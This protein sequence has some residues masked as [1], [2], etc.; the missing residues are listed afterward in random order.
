M[1]SLPDLRS[2]FTFKFAIAALAAIALSGCL[3]SEVPVLTADNGSKPPL[4]NGPYQSCALAED[5]TVDDCEIITV[6]RQNDVAMLASSDDGQDP[7]EM[8]FRRIKRKSYVAQIWESDGYAYYYA[9]GNAD[10]LVLTMMECPDLP[11]ELRDKLIDNGDLSTSDDDFEFCTV[12]T[13]KGLTEVG[14]AY[15]NRKTLN[16]SPLSLVL[17]AQK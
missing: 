8:R 7:T 2:R 9:A 14:R 10:R 12:V 5:G 13:L 4:D 6:A 17:T 3:V 15:A 11:E 16:A 1:R